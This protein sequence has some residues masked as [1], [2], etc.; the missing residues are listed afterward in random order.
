MT[1]QYVAGGTLSAGSSAYVVRDA[2]DVL[3]DRLLAGEYS[4]VL[5][6]RQMGKS[7]LMVRTAARLRQA[8]VTCAIIDL[9]AI[10]RHV[11]AQQ[12]YDGLASVLARRLGIQPPD[13]DTFDLQQ[14]TSPVLQWQRFVCES[15]LPTV[16]GSL[17]IFIDEVDVTR[18]LP[19]ADDFFASIRACYNARADDPDLNRLTFC[20]IGTASPTDLISDPMLTP[21]NI[22]ARIELRDFSVA[23]AAVLAQGLGAGE[24]A[25]RWLFDRV[26][27]WTQG[28]PYLTQRLCKEI[29]ERGGV[30]SAADVDACCRRLFIATEAAVREDNLAY[31][32]QRLT[33]ADPEA[34]TELLTRYRQVLTGKRVPDD[35]TDPQAQ[36]LKLSGVVSVR[37]GAL[38]VRNRIYAS[39]FNLAWID[40]NMPDA[41]LRRQRRA[42]RLGMRRAAAVAAVVTLA[43]CG[44][45]ALAIDQAMIARSVTRLANRRARD[46]A[47]ARDRAAASATQAEIERRRAD[48]GAAREMRERDRADA[49]AGEARRMAHV[50]SEKERLARQNAGLAELQR[51]HAERQTELVRS[52]TLAAQR[53][54]Y[55]AS[56]TAAWQDWEHGDLAGARGRLASVVPRAHLP[57]LRDFEWF[58]LDALCHQGVAR[59]PAHAGAVLALAFSPDGKLFASAGRDGFVRLWKWPSLTPHAR[60]STGQ[61]SVLSVAFS[62]DGTLLAYSGS[63]LTVHVWSVPER[64]QIA[65]LD[66]HAEDVNCVRFSPDGSLLASASDDGTVRLWNPRA[67]ACVATL[68]PR[69]AWASCLAFSA[70][71]AHLEAGYADGMQTDWDVASKRAIRTFRVMGNGLNSLVVGRDGRHSIAVGREWAGVWRTELPEGEGP[72]VLMLGHSNRVT[73]VDGSPDGKTA[74]TVSADRTARLW[75][76]ADAAAELRGYTPEL[77]AVAMSPDGRIAALGGADGA[78]YFWDLT[79]NPQGRYYATGGAPPYTGALGFTP[80]G[81]ALA[82]T[83]ETSP[84]LPNGD[85]LVELRDLRT[86][87]ILARRALRMSDVNAFALS[88]DSDFAALRL[89]P[90]TFL[91]W[92]LHLGRAVRIEDRRIEAWWHCPMAI[93]RAGRL[94]ATGDVRDGQYSVA[95]HDGATG[96][97]TRMLPCGKGRPEYLAFSPD[98]SR[99]AALTSSPESAIRLWSVSDG[100]SLWISR[101][102]DTGDESGEPPGVAFSPDGKLLASA[103]GKGA[104][105]IVDARIGST[106]ARWQTGDAR[107]GGIAFSHAGGTLA[108]Y[109]LHSNIR[110]WKVGNWQSVGQLDVRCEAWGIRFS[111][112]GRCLATWGSENCTLFDT[113]RYPQKA[114]EPWHL[115][116]PLRPVQ[117][118]HRPRKILLRPG[119]LRRLRNAAPASPLPPKAGN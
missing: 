45:T 86:E 52:E 85:T 61:K 5:T 16:G 51:A 96:R 41:E 23:E 91:I 37:E 53:S 92:D 114:F 55:V 42:Y 8:G 22:G 102:S 49:A 17:A 74:V 95:L 56:I 77:R 65:A 100:R 11:D 9:S 98:G 68:G 18:R 29:A 57:D 88:P 81:R 66:G 60:L 84:S 54:F 101:I 15:A 20:L 72:A 14:Q 1:V 107:V 108:T 39:V 7:S 12:W 58:Y 27:H 104:L 62:P 116:P 78:A 103:D 99:V 40:R 25:N 82:I 117:F 106:V 64:R 28:H 70:G 50:A 119:V 97:A 43:L 93:S 76:N 30:S 6:P 33:P 80:D 21:F 111:P 38:V 19:F 67:N 109:C 48:S 2:D 79:T 10:G 13:G 118:Q 36:T 87:R 73:D 4:H 89:D 26:Y 110:L 32:A 115:P 3:Y 75:R 94:L 69:P 44:L 63:D 83:R 113:A 90:T 46:A 105:K 59:L 35:E 47:S 31:V 24:E 71:G 34:R 112:D